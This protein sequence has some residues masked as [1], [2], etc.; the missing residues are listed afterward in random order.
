METL[1][2][3]MK[4]KQNEVETL[5]KNYEKEVNE[6]NENSES[7]EGNFLYQKDASELYVK[8]CEKVNK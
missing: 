8:M 5:V 7:V 4:N 1:K 3:M 6:I 2:Q